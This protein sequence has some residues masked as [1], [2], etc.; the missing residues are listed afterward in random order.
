MEESFRALCSKNIRT[1]P[2]LI[3][4]LPWNWFNSA[5]AVRELIKRYRSNLNAAPLASLPD[6]PRYVFCATDL[7]YGVNWIFSKD[8]VGSWQAGYLTPT[9]DGFDVAT[10][11]G[12][13]SCFP[14]IFNPLPVDLDPSQLSGGADEGDGR[15]DRVRGLRL[16]DGGVY[17]N[18]ALEPVW[19]RHAQVLVS[20]GG[21]TFDPQPD[22]GLVWRL[23]RYVNVMGNQVSALRK[24]WLIASFLDPD[25]NRS[26]QGTYWGIGSLTRSYPE[27]GQP[28]VAGYAEDLVA[29]LI[30]GVR[31]DFDRFTIAEMNVLMN[32]GY[33]LAEAATQ[34]WT[35]KLR[36]EPAPGFAV[37]YPDYMDPEVVRSAMADSHQRKFPLGRR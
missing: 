14:P 4:L 6:H 8:R 33:T 36:N 3:A 25:A 28:E 12:A 29:D 19:K 30:S 22:Q 26:L 20:D 37:P 15:D 10:A 17:D 5:T 35:P 31:T 7:T 13:S 18:M 24:R 23:S 27:K 11:V 32:H 21:S 16:S 1:L 34:R 2:L 9:A